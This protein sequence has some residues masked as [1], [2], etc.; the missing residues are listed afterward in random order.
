[1]PPFEEWIVIMFNALITGGVA[2]GVTILFRLN[3]VTNELVTAVSALKMRDDRLGQDVSKH[4][5]EIAALAVLRTNQE[6][7]A[8]R[9][10]ALK[11]QVEH[12]HTCI[13]G[14]KVSIDR[15]RE[16]LMHRAMTGDFSEKTQGRFF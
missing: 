9:Q 4:D 2:L 5:T 14:V 12:L 10:E 8:L 1:M 13:H 11:A 7:N 3:R 16:L 15:L 6:L